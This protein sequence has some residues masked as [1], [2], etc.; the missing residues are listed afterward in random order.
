VYLFAADDDVFDEGDELLNL[1]IDTVIRGKKGTS[2][3]IQ[4]T[5]KD[6]DIKP[7]VSLNATNTNIKEGSNRYATVEAQLDEVTT[8][9]VIFTVST[10]GDASDKDYVISI[11]N[12]TSQVVA[13]LA[14]HYTFG[15]NADDVSGNGNNG[16]VNGA[17]LVADRFGNASSAMY[18]DGI[19]DVITVPYVDELR[20]QKDITVNTWIKV[21]K[22]DDQSSMR[23]LT[24]PTGGPW[25]MMAIHPRVDNNKFAWSGKSAGYWDD[26]QIECLYNNCTRPDFD[27]WYM[28]TYTYGKETV[29]DDIIGDTSEVYKAK[30]YLNGVLVD[31]RYLS[32][33]SNRNFNDAIGNIYIGNGDGS[34]FFKGILDD[35]RIYDGALSA[36]Q[37]SQIY[38]QESSNS[39]VTG[40][41]YTIPAGSTKGTVYVFAV[42]D[43]EFDEST[44]SLVISI[45][46]VIYGTKSA[47]ADKATIS[48]E[49]NDV[50][51]DITLSL[52]SGDSLAE[53]SNNYATINATLSE[54]T[55]KD[56]S[57]SVGSSGTASATDFD[58]TSEKREEDGGNNSGPSIAAHYTFDGNANDISGNGNNGVTN[59]ASL[60]ID[61]FGQE[62]S[63]LYFDG[64]ND[65]VR[66]PFEGTLRIDK[67]ITINT[68]IN[69]TQSQDVNGQ[70]L[71]V[72]GTPNQHYEMYVQTGPW[73]G[74]DRF[75]AGFKAGGFGDE[76]TI[77][78]PGNNCENRPYVNMISVYS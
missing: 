19:D 10:S 4:I 42:D 16:E 37:V 39:V 11:D 41:T 70:V 61:R 21:I 49:D 5:V 25:L 30:A 7:T 71:E 9:D 66:I 28:I 32:N 14:A 27:Q 29:I 20:I 35:L 46:S 73:N 64:I 18:F 23:Y 76:S 65:V 15:G 68:W 1:E 26:V 60:V 56:V 47:T 67:D 36:E 54:V 52:T 77:D 51:P 8:A 17:T 43:E 72:Q 58:I 31:N 59:G 22:R 75:R 2:S 55:T 40:N 57:I 74:G 6:N 24:G 44:E 12:D 13:N 78:C 63:A 53:G 38:S 45:D 69:I 50:R 48:I 62:N 34:D 3:S 33:N